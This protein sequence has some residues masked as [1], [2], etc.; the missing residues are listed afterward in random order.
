M[1]DALLAE[2]FLDRSRRAYAAPLA[3]ARHV[4]RADFSSGLEHFSSVA[5]NPL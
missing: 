3:V 5:D 4:V 1:Y 2:L